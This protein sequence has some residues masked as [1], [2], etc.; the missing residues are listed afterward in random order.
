MKT[1]YR[2]QVKQFFGEI[3]DRMAD[4]FHA[5]PLRQVFDL[6][7][8]VAGRLDA[9]LN[10]DY[11]FSCSS[12]TVASIIVD[13]SPTP[14][15]NGWKGLSG[16]VRWLTTSGHEVVFVFHHLD[17]EIMIGEDKSDVFYPTLEKIC[18]I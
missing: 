15:Q 11:Q 16:H 10:I 9:R 7:Q 5:T 17:V 8:D 13:V 1:I 4:E 14:I 6:V 2:D 18:G 12:N 3:V